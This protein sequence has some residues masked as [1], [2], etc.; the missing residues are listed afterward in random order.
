MQAAAKQLRA[1]LLPIPQ[2]GVRPGRLHAGGCDA[3]QCWFTCMR[4]RQY[5]RRSDDPTHHTHH[6]P[7][8][9]NPPT[10]P[11]PSLPP[12]PPTNPTHPNKPQQTHS[13]QNRSP[14]SSPPCSATS[15]TDTFAGRTSTSSSSRTG[16]RCGWCVRD[17]IHLLCELQWLVGCASYRYVGRWEGTGPFC[18]VPRPHTHGLTLR[19]VRCVRCPALAHPSSPDRNDQAQIAMPTHART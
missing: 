17:G 14:P 16:S 11:H 9:P 6:P 2:W 12:S 1:V 18:V 4:V 8:H 10:H 13:P 15:R 19:L 5:A 3:A 7:T